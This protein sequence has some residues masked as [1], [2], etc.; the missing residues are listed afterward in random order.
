M[1]RRNLYMLI[2]ILSV[3]LIAALIAVFIFGTSIISNQCRRETPEEKEGVEKDSEDKEEEEAA[4]DGDGEE[5]GAE[6]GDGEED[7]AEDGDEEEE[8]KE[9]EEEEEGEAPAIAL[10]IYQ[11]A[12]LSGSICYYRVQA[13]VTGTPSPE[14]EWSRDDSGG[15]WGDKKAQ[16]NLTDPTETYTLTAT[17][18]NSEGSAADS[19]ELSWGCLMPNNPPEISEITFMGNHY[20]GIEYTFSVAASD[21]DGDSLTYYWTVEGGSLNDTENNPVKWT[22]PDIPGNYDITVMVNDG[23]GGEAVKREE[24]EVIEFPNAALSQAAGGGYIIK[25]TAAIKTKI[26]YVG[27]NSSNKP[28]RGYLSFDICGLAGKEVIDAEIKFD[29][30]DISGFPQDLISSIWL[31]RVNWI[32]DIKKA[33]YYLT[34]PLLGEYSIPSFTCSNQV[35]I[36]EL[37]EAIDNGEDRFQIR[38]RHKG[39]LTNHDSSWDVMCY[40]GSLLP[41]EFTVY[42]LP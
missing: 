15:T 35:L 16:V 40:G 9:E 6:D 19:I 20:T 32:G 14:V 7:G 18:T 34:G 3:V 30:Y 5:D 12:T 2:S 17:A 4:E 23:N 10:E 21:P 33:D 39:Y 22:M 1:K 26:I 37:N 38:L 8:E 42:Y 11:D 24:V 28:V 31:E 13:N 41:V 25:D 27:D 36:D 29:N